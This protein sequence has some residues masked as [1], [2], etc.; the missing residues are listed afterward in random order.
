M[1]E[2]LLLYP[3]E[4]YRRDIRTLRVKWRDAMKKVLQCGRTEE[5]QKGSLKEIIEMMSYSRRSENKEYNAR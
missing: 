4:V 5:F 2:R 1:R 3:Q